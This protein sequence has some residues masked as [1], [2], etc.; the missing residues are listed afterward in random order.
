MTRRAYPRDVPTPPP[1]PLCMP[2]VDST[3]QRRKP[4]PPRTVRWSWKGPR[5]LL[6]SLSQGC[7]CRSR[8]VC[9]SRPAHQ[10]E[11][12]PHLHYRATQQCEKRCP[13]RVV[14]HSQRWSPRGRWGCGAVMWFWG[15]A[16][17]CFGVFCDGPSFWTSS[18]SSRPADAASC[19]NVSPRFASTPPPTA[20]EEARPPR[21]SLLRL[22]TPGQCRRPPRS[23]YRHHHR[24]H[25][26]SLVVCAPPSASHPAEHQTGR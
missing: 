17:A 20:S 26:D 23:L 21:S 10:R 7:A 12:L 24:C 15:W 1:L 8:T 25:E 16:R 22:P 14:C 13:T 4:M 18:S 6:R 5:R 11:R 19:D 2:A 3:R 9:W